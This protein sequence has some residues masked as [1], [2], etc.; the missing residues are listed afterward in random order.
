[1]L[2]TST[3]RKDLEGSTELGGQVAAGHVGLASFDCGASR[4]P[5]ASVTTL[6]RV[7]DHRGTVMQAESV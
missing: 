1:M 4:G 6:M 7:K 5:V 3:Q 2:L